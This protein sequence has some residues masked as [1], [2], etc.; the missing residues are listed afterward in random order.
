MIFTSW[1]ASLQNRTSGGSGFPCWRSLGQ[2]QQRC[3]SSA[4]AR[5]SSRRAPVVLCLLLHGGAARSRGL[6]PLLCRGAAR[7]HDLPPL[8]CRVMDPW[9]PLIRGAPFLPAG[10]GPLPPRRPP[11]LL[12]PQERPSG[13]TLNPRPAGRWGGEGRPWIAMRRRGGVGRVNRGICGFF[14]FSHL[15]F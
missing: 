3:S 2:L 6:P 15:F 13:C 4:V 1:L 8:L 14:P 9:P 12:S 7:S 5:R 10:D 11:S